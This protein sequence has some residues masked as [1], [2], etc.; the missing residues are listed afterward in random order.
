MQVQG[1]RLKADPQ[2][3]PIFADFK[4]RDVHEIITF[5]ALKKPRHYPLVEANNP[6]LILRSW[7]LIICE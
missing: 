2:I 3:T 1:S 4:N 5:S 6:F 7:V